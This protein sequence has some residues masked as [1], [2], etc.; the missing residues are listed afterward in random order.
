MSRK[1]FAYYGA[2]SRQSISMTE[3]AGRYPSQRESERRIF[4][5]ISEK[6][7][8]EPDDLV[9][10]IGCGVGQLAIPISFVVNEIVGVDHPAVLALLTE[11]GHA[12][13]LAPLPG[14]FLDIDFGT[15]M[16]NK[17]LVYSV[18][19]NLTDEAEVVA[20]LKK[21]S[22][23]LLP[24]GRLLI[25][26]ISNVDRKRRFQD[27]AA[28]KVFELEWSRAGGSYSN[29]DAS[30]LTNE[31]LD[32]DRVVF[33]DEVVLRTVQTIRG[34]GLDAFVLPQPH[35]LPWGNSREDILVLRR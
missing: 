10:D 22:R 20:F 35:D 23:L 13:S 19:Q 28:G 11:R 16:F 5:D 27:S 2:L 6:L 14:N 34:W 17:I 9:L 29:I 1:S 25:G 32:E 12:P 33:T 4:F 15:R 26:D 18:V 24:A 8:L 3:R 30:Q 31:E 21:A 7:A